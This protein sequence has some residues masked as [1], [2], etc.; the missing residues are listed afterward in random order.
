MNDEESVLAQG[1]FQS[2]AFLKDAVALLGGEALANINA[3][4]GNVPAASSI[5]ISPG[6]S[7]ANI[8]H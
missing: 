4:V 6:Y 1:Y 7:P 5:H 3:A 2:H 8:H